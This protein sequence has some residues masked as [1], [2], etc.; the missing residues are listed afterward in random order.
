MSHQDRCN[1]RCPMMECPVVML[2][3][4]KNAFRPKSPKRYMLLFIPNLSMF[5]IIP[6]HVF[7]MNNPKFML[8]FN[9]H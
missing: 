5:S 6:N 1:A 3:I 8:D 7:N 2:P 9:Y 4:S